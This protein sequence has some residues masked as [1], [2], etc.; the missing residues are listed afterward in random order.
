MRRVTAALAAALVAGGCT[1]GSP[2][3]HATGEEIYI[4]LCARCHGVDLEGGV[5]PG[6]GPGSNAVLEDDS[7]LEFTIR[8]GRGRMPSFSSLDDVQIERL[9]RYLREAQDR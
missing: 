1:L 4:Q 6:L 7:Y 9:I 3:G 2:S 8:N 5:G